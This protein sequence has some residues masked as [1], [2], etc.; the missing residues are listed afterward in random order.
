VQYR[1]IA[2]DVD[3]TLLDPA[4]TLRPRVAAAVR[5]AQAAGATVTLA[6]GKLFASVRP[7]LAELD[8]AGPQIVL[9]GA[10]TL[11][12]RTGD[13]LRFRPLAEHARRRIL[14]LV[15]AADPGVLISQFGRDAIYM[16]RRHPRVGIFDEYGEGPPLFVPDLMTTPLPPAAKILLHHEP[17]RLARLRA[18][19]AA[20]V[21]D[22]VVMTT[23]SPE[24]L[25]FF[26]ESAGKGLALAAL[27]DALGLPRQA[28]LAIG[29]GENDIPM[30]REAGTAVAMGNASPVVRAA[31]AR[32]APSNDED[33]LAVILE[34]LLRAPASADPAR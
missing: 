31:A 20:D 15:R 26:D 3:G 13:T 17:E 9:N 30:F 33:G 5:A 24:F 2:L 28:V 23:T 29:D 32:T 4:H 27:R 14:A 34:D 11:D 6:T 16:D 8:L 12:S 21:P 18:R 10:A 25:E 22:G 7:L 1:L 19:L